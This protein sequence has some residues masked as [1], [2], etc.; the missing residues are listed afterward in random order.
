[1]ISIISRLIPGKLFLAFI[2]AGLLAASVWWAVGQI[3]D[4][5]QDELRDEI[6]EQNKDASDAA[7]KA[8]L[9]R[10]NCVD[11]GRVWDFG[12]SK[13]RRDR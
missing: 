4:N 10:A 7:D 8:D 13:C 5:A 6:T 3:Q 2:I 1:M 9:N 12:T 11:A